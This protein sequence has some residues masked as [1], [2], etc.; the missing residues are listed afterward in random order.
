MADRPIL[1]FPQPTTSDRAKRPRGFSNITRPGA[2]R[3]GQRLDGRFDQIR[4]ALE[5]RRIAALA[6]PG[7]VVPEEVVVLETV[8]SPRELVRAAEKV[9]GLE[10]LAEVDLDG[11]PPDEDFHD[12]KNP[13]KALSGRL[14]ALFTNQS[15]LKQ[16]LSLWAQW[17]RGEKLP[18]GLRAFDN[19]F[20]HLRDVRRWNRRDRLDETGVI[21]DWKERVEYGDEEVFTEI[22][23]WYRS[24]AERRRQAQERVTF[25]VEAEGGELLTSAQI[26][27]ICFHGLS[28]RLPI[29]TVSRI[30]ED[31]DV[32]L[33]NCEQIRFFATGQ[34]LARPIAEQAPD[35]RPP[36]MQNLAVPPPDARPVAALLDGLPVENHPALAG[37]LIV[38]DPDGYAADYQVEERRH[39]TAMASLILHGELDSPGSCTRPV[40]VRPILRPDKRDFR[41]PRLEA[42]PAEPVLVDLIHRSVQRIME[43][44]PSVAIVNL[45]IGLRDRPYYRFI[46]PLA[47]LLDWLSAEYGLLFVVSA[48]NHGQ[49]IRL[50]V[51]PAKLAQLGDDDRQALT[52]RALLHDNRHRRVLSPAEALNAL[53]VGAAHDDESG[54]VPWASHVIDPIKSP[55]LPNAASAQGH[56][57]QKVLKPDVLM[58]GGRIVLET[59]PGSDELKPHTVGLRPPGQRHAS[60]PA[61]VSTSR[62]TSNAAALVTR[63]GVRVNDVVEELRR[64]VGGNLLDEVPRGLWLRCLLAHGANWGDIE[65]TLRRGGLSDWRQVKS[66]AAR[67]VGYGRLDVDRAVTCT[68]RRVVALGGG[69][70]KEGA[71]DI[72]EFPLPPSLSGQR[73]R[74]RLV[75]TLAWFSPVNPRNQRWRR[76]HLWFG[77]GHEA[78]QLS[79]KDAD[80]I[81][82]QRGTLQHE[83]FEGESAIVINPGD[84][85]CI[86]VNCREAAGKLAQKVPY[87]LAVT[88][89]VAP[90]LNVD[91]YSE[92]KAMIRPRVRPRP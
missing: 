62:G 18:H 68:A 23:L 85:L 12:R 90:S 71:A 63:A 57:H 69:S 46:S 87:A 2:G 35:R 49:S 27:A 91:V 21:G 56:G 59:T 7:G 20:I 45:S 11:L 92:V 44:A 80:H 58:A 77:V 33:V 60:P 22:E 16:L 75:V 8:G 10:W 31:G 54:G 53:T 30:L 48:G 6:E 29:A 76:A 55:F 37:R 28:V 9:D 32:K 39:G 73:G 66:A 86:Q 65:A 19:V 14:Y 5:H 50:D 38:D 52:V 40:Y 47:Q 84:S 78:L 70:L 51:D 36:A 1:M 13:R 88:L 81:A 67:L 74:R 82:V 43:V 17:K 42:S 24:T 26:E 15:A 83:V 3:Q 25:L 61:R 64:E 34:M 89:D 41:T 79:R 72:H 4:A